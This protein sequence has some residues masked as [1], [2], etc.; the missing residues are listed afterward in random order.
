LVAHKTLQ[1]F[2]PLEENT[3]T[4]QP[5]DHEKIKNFQIQSILIPAGQAV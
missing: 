3:P 1:H 5:L 2:G 4:K